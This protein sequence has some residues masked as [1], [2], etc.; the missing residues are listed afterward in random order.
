MAKDGKEDDSP[1]A[2]ASPA[3]TSCA[4]ARSAGALGSAGIA[5]REIAEAARKNPQ[6]HRGRHGGLGAGPV[7]VRLRIN[8]KALRPQARAAH[9]A[10]RRPA[11]PARADRRQARLRPRHLRR[12][13]GAPRRQGGLRLQPCS[14]STPSASRSGPSRASAGRSELHPCRRPSSSTTPSSAAS[15]RPGF[16]M[17]AKAL[18][19]AHPKPD[20]RRMSITGSPATSAA[21]APMRA[22]AGRCSPAAPL[23]GD[24]EE[25]T[26][27]GRKDGRT[28]GTRERD[29]TEP[30]GS[31]AGRRRRRRRGG[32]AMADRWIPWPA[33]PEAADALIGTA[34]LPPGR[35]RQGERPRQVHLRSQAPGHAVGQDAALPACPRPDQVR[36]TSPPP[37]RCPASRPCGSIQKVPAPRSSGLSTRSP[38]WPPSRE[39]QAEDARA[40]RS[41]S[42]T[43]CCRTSSTRRSSPGAQG[44]SRAR[45]RRTGD[46]D[47]AM[48]AAEV[49]DQGDLSAC[50]SWPTTAWRPT[51]R[52]ATGRSRTTSPPG[53]RRRRSR[54]SPRSSPRGSASRPPTCG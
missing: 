7:P 5:G 29:R 9:D 27:R 46:P 18:L 2:A 13:H 37:R 22:C 42:S 15:A 49:Q 12:L 6:R 31:G 36:S 30:A 10:A 17:A 32:R 48:A 11:R 19:D 16:V 52:S 38:P 26:T 43:R 34:D 53:A 54:G 45:R 3:A 23:M 21:A 50:R 25:E 14:P 44:R 8:N 51:A 41:R 24:E 1:R 20:A 33:R 4:A 40:R 35:P 28:Q 39:A 47:A